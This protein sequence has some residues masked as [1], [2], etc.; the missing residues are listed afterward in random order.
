[1][2]AEDSEW[3]FVVSAIRDITKELNNKTQPVLDEIQSALDDLWGQNTQEWKEIDLLDGTLEVMSRIV[4]RV[5]VGKPLCRDPVYVSSSTRFAKMIL[6]E[7]LLIQ[8]SPGILRPL[9]GPVLAGY[10]WIQY[11]RMASRL[12][13]I[14]KERASKM[15][16]GVAEKDSEEQHDLLGKLMS[17]A[18]KRNDDPC[19]PDSHTTKLLAILNWAAIQVQTITMENAL[20]D[21]AH[22]PNSQDLQCQLREE[23]AALEGTEPVDVRWTRSEVAKLPKIDSVLA[24]SLRLWGFAHGVVKVVVAKEGVKL[25]GTG[26]HIP[27]GAKIGVGSYGVHHDEDCY[28]GSDPFTFDPFRFI[29]EKEGGEDATQ[30][31][32]ATNEK[33]LAF[34]HGKFAW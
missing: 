3:T 33:Y 12:S 23:A 18:C 28:P 13:P 29:K 34:S 24:E 32:P 31:F 15:K 20:I 30:F 2:A 19:R 26:E 4:G 17:E 6:I 16:N 25:P 10:D 5:Y 27:Y 8:L 1:V 7:A 14:I 11:R 21:V 22:A 9:F